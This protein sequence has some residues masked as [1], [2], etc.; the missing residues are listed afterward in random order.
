MAEF[1]YNNAKNGNTG[2][3]F[4]ELN[5]G[6]YPIVSYEKDLDC[7]SKSKTADY[8]V[9]KLQILMSMSKK[10]LQHNQEF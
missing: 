7:C 5:C 8:L 3:T 10:N 1:L 4:L 2:H 9:T 6:F